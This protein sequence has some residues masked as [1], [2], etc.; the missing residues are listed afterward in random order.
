MP[1]IPGL[2][3]H[4]RHYKAARE[5][6]QNEAKRKERTAPLDFGPSF[7]LDD[8]DM[9]GQTMRAYN[10]TLPDIPQMPMPNRKS[11]STNPA[12]YRPKQPRG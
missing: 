5:E 3:S 7:N 4:V 10:V 1:L 6:L 12:D 8:A 9:I 2:I 11:L